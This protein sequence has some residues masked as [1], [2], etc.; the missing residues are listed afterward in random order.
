MVAV[1][2]PTPQETAAITALFKVSGNGWW[3]YVEGL[4]FTVDHSGMQTAEQIRDAVRNI[5]GNKWL[6]VQELGPGGIW[7]GYGPN[8]EGNDMFGWLHALLK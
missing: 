5:T 6:I 2:N 7:S 3:H 4:W 1:N 8:T